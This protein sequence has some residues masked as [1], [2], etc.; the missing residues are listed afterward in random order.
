METTQPAGPP[1][2]PP[3]RRREPVPGWF[4]RALA[5]LVVT[6]L[7]TLAVLW[8][9]G[10]LRDL[11]ITLL[12]SLFLSFALE[13]AV[14]HL[15][16]RR[17]WKRGRATLFVFAVVGLLGIAFAAAVLTPL[18][19][20]TGD[21]FG[22]VGGWIDSVTERLED[23]F[24]VEVNIRAAME[25]FSSLGRLIESYADDVGRGLL[26]LGSSVAGVLF[27]LLAMALFTYYLLA[28][29]P[30]FR[31]AVLS[32]VRPELQREVLR[33]WE[34]AVQKTGGYVYSRVLLALASA[35]YTYAVLLIIGVPF[36]VPLALWVGVVSQFIP[37]V[38]TYLAAVAPV[39]VALFTDPVLAV[40]V[41]VALVAYQQVENFFLQPRITARTM[42]LHPAIAFGAVLAGAGL[43]GAIGALIA[44]PTAAIIQAFVSTYLEQHEVI[45]ELADG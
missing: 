42:A 5:L 16:R 28:D 26:G 25:D 44:L 6:I 36:A 38:G 24:G 12:L 39:L 11:L 13:P 34:V 30:R 7:G 10:R 23:W 35:V 29:G 8:V 33:M 3:R 32:S 2:A 20:Q 41:T 22:N 19:T 1:G 31:R 27:R 18:V 37:A 40:W 14:Q 9:A 45:A 17:G 4:S 21:F 15:S 43:L